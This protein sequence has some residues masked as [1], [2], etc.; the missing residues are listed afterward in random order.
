MVLTPLDL[1]SF[2]GSS[3]FLCGCLHGE[4]IR[5]VDPKDWSGDQWIPGKV[6]GRNTGRSKCVFDTATEP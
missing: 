4:I 6:G 1:H 5:V 2:W 3:A